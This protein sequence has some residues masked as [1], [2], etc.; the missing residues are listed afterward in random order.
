MDMYFRSEFIHIID[1][2]LQTKMYYI[3]ASFFVFYNKPI[4]SIW[5]SSKSISKFLESFLTLQNGENLNF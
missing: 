1:G 5:S 3:A 4:S 2:P